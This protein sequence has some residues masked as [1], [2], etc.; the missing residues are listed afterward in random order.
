MPSTT[1][2]RINYRSSPNE[3]QPSHQQPPQQQLSLDPNNRRTHASVTAPTVDSTPSASASFAARK[4][5]EAKLVS[6]ERGM[7]HVQHCRAGDACGSSL[8]HSTR[9]LMQTYENHQCPLAHQASTTTN[10]NNSNAP[11]ADCKVCKLWDFLMAR[12]TQMAAIAQLRRPLACVSIGGGGGVSIASGPSASCRVAALVAPRRAA[13]SF[14]FGRVLA[15]QKE[16]HH[17]SARRRF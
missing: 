2:T 15:A 6:L 3:P 10:S 5:W 9:R 14:V 1:P 4:Q 11:V 7:A 12:R 8:C 13:A 16:A 17:L